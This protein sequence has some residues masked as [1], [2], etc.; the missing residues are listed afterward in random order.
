MAIMMIAERDDAVRNGL[1]GPF[2]SNTR[3]LPK[4]L[5]NIVVGR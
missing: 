3:F 4:F 2:M 1:I 5:T